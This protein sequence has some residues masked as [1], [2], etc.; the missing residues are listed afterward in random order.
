[1]PPQVPPHFHHGFGAPM[2]PPSPFVMQ[3]PQVSPFAP[4]GAAP[5]SPFAP[6]TSPSPFTAPTV[7]TPSPFAPPGAAPTPPPHVP[8]AP[9]M[10]PPIVAPI[11]VAPLFT[12]PV[13]MQAIPTCPQCTTPMLWVS[14]KGSWMCTVCRGRS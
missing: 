6:P 8:P 13:Q 2:P 3:A 9:V 4:P 7:Q 11:P 12:A 14:A 10:A 1:M 5:T